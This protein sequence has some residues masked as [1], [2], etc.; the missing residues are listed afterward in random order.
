MCGLLSSV[1]VFAPVNITTN[2]YP[3]ATSLR[4]FID[5]HPLYPYDPHAPE[6]WAHAKVDA[7]VFQMAYDTAYGVDTSVEV[8]MQYMKQL[9]AVLQEVEPFDALRMQE[10]RQKRIRN[11]AAAPP[12]SETAQKQRAPPE[13]DIVSDDERDVT[14]MDALGPHLLP[15]GALRIDD[16][17]NVDPNMEPFTQSETT[18]PEVDPFAM[19]VDVSVT[20]DAEEIRDTPHSPD[21]PLSQS[22]HTPLFLP[23][24]PVPPSK[25]V[26]TPR[27]NT[28]EEEEELDEYFRNLGQEN[29]ESALQKNNEDLQSAN[30]IGSRKRGRDEG[31]EDGGPEPRPAKLSKVQRVSSPVHDR[32]DSV[33]VAL[34]L[35]EVNTEQE[36]H[37]PERAL[38]KSSSRDGTPS[39][40]PS[41]A[42]SPS[43]S[44]RNSTPVKIKSR[45]ISPV[46]DTVGSGLIDTLESEEEE[47]EEEDS[48]VDTLEP[49]EEEEE[50]EEPLLDTL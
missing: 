37:S 39:N 23:D 48:L 43:H 34:S 35:A 40:H 31:D 7:L 13:E 27:H 3:I 42:S 9:D 20:G 44:S 32:Q 29:K 6:S 45:E 30:A 18:R 49:E 50:G 14:M 17:G 8:A 11:P 41:R 38:V 26:S 10:R 2:V 25:T 1:V 36:S 4:A 46:D 33:G 19:N 16:L 12:R 28:Q 15:I 21:S 5:H 47:E 24:S 22:Q